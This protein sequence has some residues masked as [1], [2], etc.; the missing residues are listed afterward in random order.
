MQIRSIKIPLPPTL[1]EQTAI[2]TA[3]SDTD[4]LIQSLEKLIAKKRAIKQGAMQELLTGKKRLPGFSEKWEEKTF[5]DFCQPSKKRVNPLTCQQN[6]KCI[7]LEHIEPETGLLIGSIDSNGQLSQKAF[8]DAGNVLFGKLRP[9]LQKFLLAPYSG[10]CSTEIWVLVPTLTISNIFLYYLVQSAKFIEAANQSTG[11]KM[12]RAEWHTVKKTIFKFPPTTEEQTA[13]AQILSD[14]DSE[15]T[16]LKAKL[17]KSRAIKQGMMQ[18][19]LTGKI[20]LN[21]G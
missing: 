4:A 19:L 12:P 3:L 7:E 18:E 5:G 10:V 20:R 8:F 2:A 16:A 9:Y 11:T 21:H 17:A 6:Y 15:L 14:M 1:A 13:I